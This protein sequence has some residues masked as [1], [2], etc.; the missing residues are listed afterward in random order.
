MRW[1]LQSKTTYKKTSYIIEIQHNDSIKYATLF[2]F[3]IISVLNQ[4]LQE[5]IAEWTQMNNINTITKTQIY[6]NK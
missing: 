4:Q 2:K 1:K 3:F 6:M 5:P